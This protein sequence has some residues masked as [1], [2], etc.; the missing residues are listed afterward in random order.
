MEWSTACPDWERRIVQ[1]ESLITSPPLFPSLADEAWAICSEFKLKDLGY[2]RLRRR[3]AALAAGL[4][5][6]GLW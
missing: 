3:L 4:C 5:K 1:R 2:Q 6:G